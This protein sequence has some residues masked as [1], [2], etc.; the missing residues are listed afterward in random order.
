MK[1]L[2]SFLISRQRK[3]NKQITKTAHNLNTYYKKF[4]SSSVFNFCLLKILLFLF[5]IQMEA[6]GKTDQTSPLY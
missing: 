3:R 5:W 4:C 6:L 1:Y 2:N